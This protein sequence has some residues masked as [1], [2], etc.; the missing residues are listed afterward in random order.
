MASIETSN[1]WEAWPLKNPEPS[2]MTWHD[3]SKGKEAIWKATDPLRPDSIFHAVADEYKVLM[4]EPALCR[5]EDIPQGFVQ[6]CCLNE[7]LALQRNPYFSAVSLLAQLWEVTC[8][9]STITRYLKFLGFM[10]SRFRSLLHQKDP[11]ALLILAYWY[12]PMCESLWWIA[13][14]AQLECQAICI[15][16]EQYHNDKGDIQRMLTLPK[17]QCGLLMATIDTNT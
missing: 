12:A 3:M 1:P 9:P 17:I 7:P 16:L 14:R 8:T 6:L 15:Y 11:R 13:G 4:T 5:V 10:N 2:D